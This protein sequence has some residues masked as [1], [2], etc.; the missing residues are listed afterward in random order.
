MESFFAP[1]SCC[2]SRLPR[3]LSQTHF[4]GF[5]LVL[6]WVKLQMRILVS[7]KG[8]FHEHAGIC[9]RARVQKFRPVFGMVCRRDAAFR[10]GFM[11][12][13]SPANKPPARFCPLFFRFSRIFVTRTFS[14]ARI[15]TLLFFAP[16][17]PEFRSKALIM[18]RQTSRDSSP[19][20]A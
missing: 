8:Y 12:N 10:A 3:S 11:K 15:R 14:R 13:H 2:L 9:R 6:L 4:I 7:E 5:V 1:S 19:S 18:C 16:K 17:S 20:L